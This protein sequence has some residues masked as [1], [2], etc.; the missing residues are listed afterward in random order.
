MAGV[1]SADTGKPCEGAMYVS[2]LGTMRGGYWADCRNEASSL[3]C[4][5]E[6]HTWHMVRWRPRVA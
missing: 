6:F 2:V 4:G 1:T 3:R 5:G